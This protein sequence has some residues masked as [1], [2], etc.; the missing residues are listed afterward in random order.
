MVIDRIRWLRAFR[1]LP[2]ANVHH[3]SGVCFV[4]RPAA[5][6]YVLIYAAHTRLHIHKLANAVRLLQRTGLNTL[7]NRIES[8]R[9]DGVDLIELCGDGL[10][11]VLLH[12]ALERDGIEQ[13]TG[14]AHAPR[15]LVG[16]PENGIRN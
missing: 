11:I 14:Y 15:E 12:E 5:L 13:A 16:S 9:L 6:V 2:P 1:R 10:V 8:G 4:P 7:K 3:A